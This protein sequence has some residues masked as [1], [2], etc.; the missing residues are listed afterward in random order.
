MV[1]FLNKI[2]REENCRNVEILKMIYLYYI[3]RK[4]K[5][6]IKIEMHIIFYKQLSNF[7]LSENL[8]KPLKMVL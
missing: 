1:K 8:S 7:Y 6:S 5:K 3:Q 2:T 4:K